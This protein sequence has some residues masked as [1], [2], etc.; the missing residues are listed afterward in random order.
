[1]LVLEAEEDLSGSDSLA[2][3]DPSFCSNI[4]DDD[5]E[6][7]IV[8]KSIYHYIRLQEMKVFLYCSK[9]CSLVVGQFGGIIRYHNHNI[10]TVPLQ[11]VRQTLQLST[12]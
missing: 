10:T 1:M 9:E 11:L 6:G 3:C 4:L 5:S 7:P 2:L 12:T 8:S